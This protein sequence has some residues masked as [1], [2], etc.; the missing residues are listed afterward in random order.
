MGAKTIQAD[1]HIVTIDTDRLFLPEEGH[2][3]FRELKSVKRNVFYHQI[4]SIHGHDAFLI[5]FS[6]LSDILNAVL[7]NQKLI[8]YARS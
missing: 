2:K 5:E 8:V 1:I 3:T 7:Y 4:Q 6:R